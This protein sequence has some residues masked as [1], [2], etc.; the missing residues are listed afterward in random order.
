MQ[1]TISN[2]ISFFTSP[3]LLTRHAQTSLGDYQTILR[4]GRKTFIGVGHTPAES[5]KN[6]VDAYD[7]KTGTCIGSI[8][9]DRLVMVTERAHHG[10]L[11]A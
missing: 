8:M 3:K 6:A 10:E 4:V 2:I 11:L 5:R 9:A 7:E 1:H